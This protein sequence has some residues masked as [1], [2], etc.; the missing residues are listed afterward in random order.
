MGGEF[1]LIWLTVSN[2]LERSLDTNTVRRESVLNEF[3]FESVK[4]RK[5]AVMIDLLKLKQCLLE[6]MEK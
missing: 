2:T 4:K 1:S 6:D 3:M 5:R